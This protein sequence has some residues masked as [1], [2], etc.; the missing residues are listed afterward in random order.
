M[1]AIRNASKRQIWVQAMTD[2][3]IWEKAPCFSRRFYN[4][5][6]FIG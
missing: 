6:A 3:H 5:N 2:A 1:F 4:L